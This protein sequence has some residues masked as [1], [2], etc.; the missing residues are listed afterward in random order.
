MNYDLLGYNADFKNGNIT[1]KI[2]NDTFKTKPSIKGI[3]DVFDSS[4]FNL[5]NNKINAKVDDVVKQVD[6]NSLLLDKKL[7]KDVSDVI[8]KDIKKDFKDITDTDLTQINNIVDQ[9]IQSNPGLSDPKRVGR[10]VALRGVIM[11]AVGKIGKG[12]NISKQDRAQL[13]SDLY[14]NYIQTH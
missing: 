1:F 6:I 14:N 5:I 11:G 10:G 4:I 12:L 13:Y 3:N 8:E 9:Y 2:H 7:L